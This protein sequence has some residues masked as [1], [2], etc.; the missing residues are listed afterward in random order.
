VC[1][2]ALG[3]SRA[4]R[5]RKRAE[6]QP[7]YRKRNAEGHLVWARRNPDAVSMQQAKQTT[8]ATRTINAVHATAIARNRVRRR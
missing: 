8:D 3:Y 7:L 6:D 2:N 1:V 5:A 4:H